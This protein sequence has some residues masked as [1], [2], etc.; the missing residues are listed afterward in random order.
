MPV[1]C[2]LKQAANGRSDSRKK[3]HRLV[4]FPFSKRVTWSC[5]S[6]GGARVYCSTV[7]RPPFL[8]F[9]FFFL[10]FFLFLFFSPFFLSFF[11]FFFFFYPHCFPRSIICVKKIGRA[12]SETLGLPSQA[13]ISRIYRRP[14]RI[15]SACIIGSREPGIVILYSHPRAMKINNYTHT[16]RFY[17]DSY[18]ILFF[19]RIFMNDV[20]K[21]SDMI[22]NIT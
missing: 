12:I 15:W 7:S 17:L 9:L 2:F 11:S 8:S 5:Y 21:N 3:Y 13:G 4:P 20:S 1:T 19:F 18:I 22:D 14:N 10:S 6:R 16:I